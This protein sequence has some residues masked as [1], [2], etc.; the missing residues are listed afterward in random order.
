MSS[1]MMI[2]SYVVGLVSWMGPN[3]IMQHISH[4]SHAAQYSDSDRDPDRGAQIQIKV[5][6]QIAGPRSRSNLKCLFL[7]SV[8]SSVAGMGLS[9][10]ANW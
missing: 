7:N 6:I 10:L 9:P 3:K 1:K 8:T 2:S 4:L 5:K